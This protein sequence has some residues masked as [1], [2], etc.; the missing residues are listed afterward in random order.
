MTNLV[1]AAKIKGVVQHYAWGGF[2]FIPEL[3]AAQ[4]ESNEPFA[5]YWMGAHKNAPATLVNVEPAL[6]L[7]ELIA[8]NPSFYL[9]EAVA[10]RF[11]NQLPFLFKVLDVKDMLS[12]QVHPTKEEAV[13]GFARENQEG[14]PANAPHRNYKDDNHKPEIMVAV[15]EFYLLHGFKPVEELKAVL[16]NTE[17]FKAFAPIFGE[18][19]YKALYAHIMQLP[20]AEVDQIL[21]PLVARISEDY[22]EGNLEK[23][24]SDFWAA[25]TVEGQEN[26]AEQLDRG[27]FSI[28]FFNVVKVNKG[29]AVFQ[30]AGV[31]HAYLE[32][33]NMELMA[34]SDNVLRGGLTPK[35]IDVPELLKHTKFEAT[36]PN[37]LKGDDRSAAEKVYTSPAPDFEVSRVEVSTDQ[38]FQAPKGHSFDI[39]VM[40]EGQTVKVTTPQ[41]SYTLSKGETGMVSANIDYTIEGE[42]LL[43][44]ATVP[45]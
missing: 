13:K 5:E 16:N 21:A 14:I 37:I 34:N 33:V 45:Q 2:N 44:R 43:F 38:K 17:E 27:I 18:G 26:I 10:K 31:P 9:G 12:I 40:L 23:T 36:I 22:Q 24:S 28:Y 29:D 41:T 30:D 8:E 11:D 7:N 39:L 25:K 15:T 19:D 20:Q 3:I 4:N 42:G 6:A 35:H 32:G 1:E